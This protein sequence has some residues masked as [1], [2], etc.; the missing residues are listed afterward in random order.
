MALSL[1]CERHIL[2]ASLAVQP[3]TKALLD[4][5]RKLTVLNMLSSNLNVGKPSPAKAL[6]KK[7]IKGFYGFVQVKVRGL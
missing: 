2:P 1:T 5:G 4:N 7:E 6:V 3:S